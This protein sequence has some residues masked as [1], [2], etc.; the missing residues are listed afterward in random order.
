MNMR[1]VYLS[2]G[3]AV[4]SATAGANV[5]T[6]SNAAPP[7]KQA[8]IPF[9]NHGGIRN[10]H[11]DRNQGLWVQD[12]HR[13][14]YYAKFFGPCLGVNFANSL[15]FDTG[16][17]GTFDRFSSIVVPREGRCAIQSFVPS[18]GPPSKRKA[19]TASEAASS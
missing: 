2:L 9:A 7:S 14:W 13:N 5:A 18:E 6:A 3:L 16:T 8:S 12:V 10:W 15:G 11:A 1:N 19:A 4:L 17:I